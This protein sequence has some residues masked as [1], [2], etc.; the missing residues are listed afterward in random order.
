MSSIRL[1]EKRETSCLYKVFRLFFCCISSQDLLENVTDTKNSAVQCNIPITPT[2]FQNFYIDKEKIQRDLQPSLEKLDTLISTL[3][4]LYIKET[5]RVKDMERMI[6][7]VE[8][9]TNETIGE[10]CKILDPFFPETTL[11]S[12]PVI[13]RRSFSEYSRRKNVICNKNIRENAGRKITILQ[14]NFSQLS[15]NFGLFSTNI[16]NNLTT[17]QTDMNSLKHIFDNIKCIMVN[18]E[19]GYVTFACG[20]FKNL[21]LEPKQACLVGSKDLI[22]AKISV[23]NFC[24]FYKLGQ[25]YDRKSKRK[26]LKSKIK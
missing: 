2:E 22:G 17:I 21:F 4:Q 8:E 16:S 14:S 20:G 13:L 5:E 7:N 24:R 10:Q 11:N 23:E 12:L 26:I 9:D 3:N 1:K 15:T 18:E 19:N 25:I 6:E